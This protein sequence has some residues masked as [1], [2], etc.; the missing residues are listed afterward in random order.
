M[1]H[2]CYVIPFFPDV[3]VNNEKQTI[4]VIEQKFSM[5]QKFSIKQKFSIEQY[6]QREKICNFTWINKQMSKKNTKI[7]QE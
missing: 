4:Q 3:P 5:E 2:R 1:L 7:F 6:I